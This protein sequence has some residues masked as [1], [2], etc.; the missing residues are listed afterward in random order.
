MLGFDGDG[1]RSV[2]SDSLMRADIVG[3]SRCDTEGV[4]IVRH[5][6]YYQRRKMSRTAS[7]TRLLYDVSGAHVVRR[8]Q[9]SNCSTIIAQLVRE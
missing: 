7:L 2:Y 4:F 5:G 1:L 9:H 8:R 3:G 6:M